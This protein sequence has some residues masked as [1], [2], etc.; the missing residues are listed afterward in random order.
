MVCAT[1]ARPTRRSPHE[2][3][4]PLI[5]SNPRRSGLSNY[6]D[7]MYDGFVCVLG[8]IERGVVA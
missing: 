8:K 3:E 4:K 5:D 1:I 2:R 6:S 7:G